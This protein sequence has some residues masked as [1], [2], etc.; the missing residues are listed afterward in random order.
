MFHAFKICD[1]VC[2]KGP[3]VGRYKTEISLSNVIGQ[4]WLGLG[5]YTNQ[6]IFYI[7][8]QQTVILS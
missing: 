7:K 8:K 3:L 1:R 6:V 2:I 4:F 5:K